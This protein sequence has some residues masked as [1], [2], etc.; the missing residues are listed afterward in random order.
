MQ[1]G[2]CSSQT[3]SRCRRRTVGTLKHRRL[4]QGLNEDRTLVDVSHSSRSK[5][6]LKSSTYCTGLSVSIGRV[7][8]CFWVHHV[9]LLRCAVAVQS[10]VCIVVIPRR[11]IVPI[12]CTVKQWNR[13]L[14]MAV[15]LVEF[16][17][18]YRGAQEETH[19]Q[20]S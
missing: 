1:S 16:K 9:P 19:Q 13:E 7:A 17:P 15:S 5:N 6:S 4:R 10:R 18:K 20:N 8:A 3:Y 11:G 12:P 2:S 14:M